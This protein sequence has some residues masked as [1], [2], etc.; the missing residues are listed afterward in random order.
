MA[1]PTV[2]FVVDE[3]CPNVKAARANLMRAFSSAGVPAH[4]QE[5]LIG[6]A[7]APP[8]VRGFGSPTILVNGVDV[9]GLG[10]GAEDCC[11]VYE[12]GGVP[13]VELIA[14]ALEP[15]TNQPR[16]RNHEPDA[17]PARTPSSSRATSRAP[18]VR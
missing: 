8:H 3:D 1:V 12:G 7:E 5:H 17:R 18:R 9:G 11:R 10:A 2:D 14:A 13:S 4:W 15:P 6:S 16:R